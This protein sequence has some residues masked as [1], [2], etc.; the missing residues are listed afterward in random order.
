MTENNLSKIKIAIGSLDD[1]ADIVENGYGVNY[2]TLPARI[3]ECTKIL[4]DNIN[5]ETEKPVRHEIK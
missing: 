1:L 4:I 2:E 3:R 5:L